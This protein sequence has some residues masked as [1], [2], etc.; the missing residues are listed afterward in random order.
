MLFDVGNIGLVYV[1]V[2][3]C[4]GVWIVVMGVEVFGEGF[5]SVCVVVFVGKE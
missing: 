2:C 4:D 3:S 1:D 5:D